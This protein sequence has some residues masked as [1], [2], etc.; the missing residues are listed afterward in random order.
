[1]SKKLAQHTRTLAASLAGA[2]VM[3]TALTVPAQAQANWPERPASRNWWVAVS[4][5]EPAS[6]VLRA[7]HSLVE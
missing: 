1:M 3:A 7:H 4:P 2:L 5:I 6:T